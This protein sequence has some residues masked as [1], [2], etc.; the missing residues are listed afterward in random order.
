MA[1]TLRRTKRGPIARRLGL[2]KGDQVSIQPKGR[3]TIKVIGSG[4][5]AKVQAS[6]DVKVIVTRPIGNKF[7]RTR[8]A[9]FT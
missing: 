2:K 7:V 4:R 1:R 6:R 8:R 3:P 9:K 5:S